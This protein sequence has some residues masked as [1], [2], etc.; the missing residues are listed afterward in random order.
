MRTSS[1]EFLLYYLEELSYLRQA[2]ERFARAYPK[3]AGRLE[4]QRDECPDPHV[5]RLIEAFAFLTARIQSDLDGD[6]PEVAAELLNVLYPHYLNP[7]PPMTVVRFDVDPKRGKLTSGHEIPRHT[8]I[9]TTAE[10]GAVCRM[11]TA[12][13]VTLWPVEVKSAD[14][15]TPDAFE[16]L[17]KS[18]DVVAVLRLRLQ[19]MADPFDKLEIDRLRFY[20]HGEPVLVG[21]LYELLMNNLLRVAVLPAGTKTPREIPRS[22]VVPAGFDRDEDVIPYPRYS[23]P[24][25]RLLQEYFVF[26]E[27]FHFF[28][29]RR[30]RGQMSGEQVDVLFLLDKAPAAKL[31]L[32]PETFLLGCAPAINLFRRTSEPIRV[33]HR[34]LEYRLVPD[35][36]REKTTEIHSVLSVSGTSD[37]TDPTRD[38]APFYSYTH[39]MERRKQRAFWHARRVPAQHPEMTGTDVLLSFRDLDF[40]P[41]RPPDEIVYAHLLCTNRA[42]A[43]EIPAGGTLQSDDAAPVSQIV[44]LKKP[45]RPVDPPLGGQALWRLV[46]H[47]SL[48]Y[49][50]LGETDDSLKALREIL[51][52]YCL[53]DA[54]AQRQQIHGIRRMS[55]R[56]VVRR[57]DGAAW[58][59]FCRGTEVELLFDESAFVG[60]SAFLFASV[61]NHFLG[62]F[63]STN[64]FTQLLVRRAA[65]ESEVWKLWRP[66]S[67]AK[68]VL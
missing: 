16:F 34:Q 46:S 65:R 54:P 30:L 64:S 56:K 9:F 52:L 4:L 38:Y 36:R 61:I 1:E 5:E 66:M 22:A 33:D 29:L 3:V 45:T 2:G 6:F 28:D 40:S 37:P 41:A 47:L 15:E 13:P 35:M 32:T 55:H 19:S 57:M 68:A 25:Y 7:V 63:A 14:V 31:L 60:G 49:L 59:G 24:A 21:R 26:P 39:A 23:H 48:N 51:A 62:L 18:T 43:A 10:R 20:L 27:K 42:L 44:C 50:A 11:R 67:G 8:Q 53:Q 17:D 12:Y 58:K